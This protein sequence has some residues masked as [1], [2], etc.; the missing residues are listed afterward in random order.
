MA[1]KGTIMSIASARTTN[2]K[3]NVPWFVKPKLTQKKQK[4]HSGRLKVLMLLITLFSQ[5]MKALRW[6]KTSVSIGD[7]TAGS[8][9]KVLTAC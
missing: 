1:K 4:S 3:E 7:Q 8:F 5:G 6:H 2:G 9:I